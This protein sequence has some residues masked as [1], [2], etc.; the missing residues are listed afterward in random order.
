M[1]RYLTAGLGLFLGASAHAQLPDLSAV[2]IKTHAVTSNIY[3]LQGFGGNIGVLIGDDGAFVIDDQLA[4]LSDKIKAAIS[5]LTDGPAE[6]LVNTHHHFDH[7]GGNAAFG[8]HTH[9]VA[10]D[11]VRAR[12]A[13]GEEPAPAEALPVITFSDRATFY[14][15]GMKIE[16]FHL[17]KAHTDGDTVVYFPDANVIHTGDLLFSG[18][19]PFVDLNGGGD[20]DGYI[21]AMQAIV[22]LIDEDTKVI[23]GHGPLSSQSDLEDSI[24]MMKKVRKKIQKLIDKGLD[25]D[26]VVAAAPT[27]D[28]DEDWNWEFINGEAITRAA[29]Q[30]LTRE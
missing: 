27:A 4:P 11:N 14:R 15:S 28:F 7:T 25:E 21:D 17:S 24:A 29:Y 12:L 8:A 26:A 13:G 19:Y 2:E 22:D 1:S 3:M 9:I 30:S 10:H 5:A 18:M 20:Y 23:P 16:L 6:F